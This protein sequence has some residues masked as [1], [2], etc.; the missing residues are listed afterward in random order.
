MIQTWLDTV[1]EETLLA[2]GE[3]LEVVMLEPG[4]VLFERGDPGDS[5][6]LVVDGV[7]D[8]VIARDDGDEWVIDQLA[9]GEILG[10]M[11][12]LSGQPRSAMVRA[13]QATELHRLSKYDFD[14]L[15]QRDADLLKGLNE[16]VAPRTERVHLVD[17]LSDLFGPLPVETLH[18]LQSTCTLRHV[19][20]GERVVL[21]G[22]AVVVTSGRARLTVVVDDG[23]ERAGGEVGRGDAAGP[24]CLLSGEVGDAALVALTDCGLI[25]VR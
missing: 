9:A 14:A 23:R 25:R 5:M 24:F 8:V 4:Q 12:L 18:A 17:V 2:L 1:A 13:V 21:A 6:Y 19:G 7:L 16:Y 11:A 22:E 15:S 20:A 10:E 3:R